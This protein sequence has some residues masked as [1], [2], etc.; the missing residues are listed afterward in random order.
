MVLDQERSEAREPAADTLP[1]EAVLATAELAR[2]PARPPGSAAENRAL[3]AL[4][5]RLAAAP[6]GILQDLAE[7]ALELCGAHS[8]GVSLLDERGDFRWPAIAG[9][10]APRVGG[11]MP[12][13][14]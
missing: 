4:A 14:L 12:R 5:E 9:R 3:V 7:H 8:A 2:R 1:L 11:G 10:W 13:A 6:D